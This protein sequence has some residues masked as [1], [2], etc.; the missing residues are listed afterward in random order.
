V[1][2][3]ERREAG[4]GQ[5]AGDVEHLRE[6]RL[7]VALGDERPTDL[8]EPVEALLVEILAGDGVGPFPMLAPATRRV[9][10]TIARGTVPLNSTT[11][12]AAGHN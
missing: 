3:A 9:A 12:E 7:E 1:E 8:D 5:V 11:R 10:R 2:H 4:A 6:E